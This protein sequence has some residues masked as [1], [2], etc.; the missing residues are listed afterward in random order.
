[1]EIEGVKYSHDSSWKPLA[2]PD[3]FVVR[4]NKINSGNGEAKYYVGGRSDP[5]LKIFF[6]KEGHS[7][8]GVLARE[9]L[10]QFLKDTKYEYFHPTQPYKNASSFERLWTSRLEIV[11]K[12]KSEYLEFQFEEQVAGEERC[13]IKGS[14]NSAYQLLRELPLPNRARVIIE[15]FC[16][17][18]GL[19]IFV[20]NLR[21]SFS[22]E[23][24]RLLAEKV[25]AKEIES[26]AELNTQER[27]QLVLAQAGLG[28]Y[29]DQIIS[30]CGAF[31]PFT[32]IKDER[33]LVTSHIKPWVMSNN[34]ERLNPQNGFVFS[35]LY[36]RLFQQG[37]I[38]FSDRGVVSSSSSLSKLLLGDLEIPNI[39]EFPLAVTGDENAQRRNFLQFHRRNIFVP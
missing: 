33:L 27:E 16:S 4:D 36:S 18:E 17:H 7:F 24:E 38:T 15:K 14:K 25:H 3:S 1:M 20:F 9:D 31:C 12:F 22:S 11:S 8:V 30:S 13:Y 37:L 39:P 28:R 23:A 35:P 32:G 6:G 26:N 10:I 21:C 2:I 29:R 19:E 34:L 5:K